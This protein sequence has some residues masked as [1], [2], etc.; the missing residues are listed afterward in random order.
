MLD[1]LPL[2]LQ[3]LNNVFGREVISTKLPERNSISAVDGRWVR[4]KSDWKTKFNDEAMALFNEIN[5]EMMQKM[6]Y[7]E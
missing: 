7:L 3:Q 6:G 5:R 2:V 1:N 4:K